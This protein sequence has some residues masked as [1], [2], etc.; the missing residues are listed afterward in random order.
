MPSL[1]V[2]FNLLV[3]GVHG[4]DVATARIIDATGS[5]SHAGLLQ[6]KTEFGLGSV[7]GMTD[8]S[9]V[10]ACKQLGYTYG[11]TVAS[12]CSSFG[13]ENACGTVGSTVAMK[14]V[15]CSGDK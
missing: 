13:G 8:A 7:C 14:N 2:S 10:V 5:P 11:A 6:V 9:A 1:P 15:K 3:L 4:A 12:P